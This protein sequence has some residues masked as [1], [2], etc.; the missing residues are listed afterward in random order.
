[1]DLGFKDRE[2]EEN[3]AWHPRQDSEESNKNVTLGED[4]FEEI[5]RLSGYRGNVRDIAAEDSRC[6]TGSKQDHHQCPDAESA[7]R[8]RLANIQT[9]PS[10][11]SDRERSP[12]QS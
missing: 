8:G 9:R 3:I 2:T 7:R 5:G 1:M 11:Q 4:T 10:N 12:E 6:E